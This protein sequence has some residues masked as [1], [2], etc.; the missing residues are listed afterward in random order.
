MF[1]KHVKNV[2]LFALGKV[3]AN[4]FFKS[5]VNAENNH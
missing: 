5:L 4:L 2:V 3:L 1:N